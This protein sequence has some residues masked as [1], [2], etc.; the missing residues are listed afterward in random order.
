[1]RVKV[2][3]VGASGYAV[4]YLGLMLQNMDSEKFSLEGVVDVA[5]DRSPYCEALTQHSIPV[6]T[7]LED[8]FASGRKADLV[9]IAS[10]PHFHA[11][12]SLLAIAN[13]A[14]V[15]CEKPIAPLYTDALAMQKAADEAGKFVAIAYQWSYTDAVQNLK[16]DILAGV[17][18]KP[19][20][21][22]S[23]V[24]WPRDW[25][26]YSSWKGKIR[27]KDGTWILDSVIGNATA[28]Y[29]HNM[30]FL[31]GKEMDTCAFPGEI[32]SEL[33][34]ANDIENFDTCLL[35]ITTTDGDKIYCAVSH[36]VEKNDSPKFQFTFE[37]AV[38]SCN[39]EAIDNEIIAVFKDGTVK[40]Y[41][42]PNETYNYRFWEA[43][44]SVVSRKPMK[45]TVK[46]ALALTKTVAQLYAHGE[47]VN[48]PSE[49][50]YQDEEKRIT[51]VHG[52]YDLLYKA[53]QE[54]KLFSDMDI[55]W[56][57]P[58]CFTVDAD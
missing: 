20:L 12:Q 17:L 13:G 11:Q 46:T 14:D 21:M 50:V 34:R 8:F 9:I 45:C 41:G 25:N 31:L 24:A 43:L 37:N 35:D 22:K 49:L 16:K 39:M 53:F 4:N 57:K 3:M 7:S 40:R 2:A 54:G 47:I 56:A 38:V 48:Y 6:F 19:Q 28:H 1:M 58:V 36:A 10:P 27:G 44:D 18:G 55:P 52:L 23:F 26:Y 32:R 15:L 33:L 30:Y 5:I 42:N 29:L 51:G